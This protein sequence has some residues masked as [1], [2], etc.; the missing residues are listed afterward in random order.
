M[1]PAYDHSPPRRKPIPVERQAIAVDS[2][3]AGVDFIGKGQVVDIDNPLVRRY[4]ELFVQA[5]QPI[6]PR[7][8]A[9]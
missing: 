5:P 8:E 2:F 3:S 7:G 4:P 6:A 9:A 1:P